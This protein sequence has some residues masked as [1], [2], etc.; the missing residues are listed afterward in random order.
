MCKKCHN[1]KVKNERKE[2]KIDKIIKEG[3]KAD[4]KILMIEKDMDDL[5]HKIDELTQ[6]INDF[7]NPILSNDVLEVNFATSILNFY[8]HIVKSR[9]NIDVM[10]NNINKLRDDL[11]NIIK[12]IKEKMRGNVDAVNDVNDN[13]IVTTNTLDTRDDHNNE[14]DEKDAEHVTYD[15]NKK[16]EIIQSNS[17]CKRGRPK[18]IQ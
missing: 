1:E 8:N 16:Q 13:N 4:V 2:K 5:N 18:K 15:D 10:N 3:A 12:K 7:V 6:I 14:L 9:N 17:I 11:T